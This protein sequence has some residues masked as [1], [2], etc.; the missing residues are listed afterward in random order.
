[1]TITLIKA[2]AIACVFGGFTLASPAYA[3]TPVPL[4][5]ADG[6]A[7]S[8][9]DEEDEAVLEDLRPDIKAPGSDDEEPAPQGQAEG[10]TEDEG[11]IGEKEIERDEGQRE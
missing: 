9:A 2:S 1:M 10:E 6:I 5:G 4:G 3:V 7:I 11:D 8:V